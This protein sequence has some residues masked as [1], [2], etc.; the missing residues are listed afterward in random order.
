MKFICNN[1]FRELLQND[2]THFTWVHIKQY[3]NFHTDTTT[4]YT[5][6]QSSYNTILTFLKSYYQ[7]LL[8]TFFKFLFTQYIFRELFFKKE[9][10]MASFC[11]WGSTASRLEPLQGDNLLFTC[12]FLVLTLSTSEGWNAGATQWFWTWDP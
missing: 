10:F 11:G 7:I 2:T 8:H 1:T 5:F 9:N 6:C 3:W 12:K 4:Q